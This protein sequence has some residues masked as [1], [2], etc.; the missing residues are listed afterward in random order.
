MLVVKSA[1]HHRWQQ[2]L[3]RFFGRHRSHQA[4]KNDAPP[5]PQKAD[6]HHHHHLHHRFDRHIQL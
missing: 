5:T 6:P 2:W 1:P 3:T 4:M